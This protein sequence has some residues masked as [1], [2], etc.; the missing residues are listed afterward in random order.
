[1]VA[2]LEGEEEPWV[3][4]VVDMTL[5]SRAEA[6]RGPGLGEWGWGMPCFRWRAH[7]PLGVSV[8]WHCGAEARGRTSFPP[9][10][11]L[12]DMPCG[13][14]ISAMTQALGGPPLWPVSCHFP[15][16]VL[17]QSCP[18][19]TYSTVTHVLKHYSTTS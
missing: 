5:V 8:H 9:S 19:V 17:V 11:S 1:M 14:A 12:L 10:P 4:S 3:P 16:S 15:F 13:L 18:L 6:G 2:Q 7:Q